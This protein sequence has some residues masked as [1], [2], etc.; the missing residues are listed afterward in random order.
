MR[1]VT[2]V[3]ML[4]AFCSQ[5]YALSFMGPPKADLAQG[6][7]GLGIDYTYSEMDIEATF[8]GEHWTEEI[9]TNTIFTNLGYGITDKWEGFLRLG[10]SDIEAE[11]FDSG[12]DFAYGFGTKF[13]FAEQDSVSWGALFQIGWLTGEDTFTGFLPGF[14]IVN[15]D[16]E[17]DAYEIQIAIGPTWEIDNLKVYGGPFFHFIDG[18]YDL[19][20]LGANYS[21]DL[22]QESV[23]GG[24][25][26]V[27]ADLDESS[28]VGVE[29]QFT[30]DADAIGIRYVRR[31]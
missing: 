20:I 4:L 16:Q 3:I 1:T 11:D 13:T 28:N 24:F 22:E 18:E 15:V 26:G 2:I 21:A 10:L 12:Y 31:F 7:Y 19:D 8:L 6:Q 14:G 23:F 17:I 25:I 9:E 29:F 5:A 27:S 30:G